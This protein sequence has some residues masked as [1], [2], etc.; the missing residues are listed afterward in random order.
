VEILAVEYRLA[1]AFGLVRDTAVRP[2]A[3]GA[4]SQPLNHQRFLNSHFMFRSIFGSKTFRA[5]EH[6]PFCIFRMVRFDEHR[7]SH[8]KRSAIPAMNASATQRAVVQRRFWRHDI[9]TAIAV[10]PPTLG[11]LKEPVILSVAGSQVNPVI[12]PSWVPQLQSATGRHRPSV[13]P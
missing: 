2:V 4:D 9:D 6:V 7:P 8:R 11:R 5:W 3:G 13:V 1:A 12:G 10:P